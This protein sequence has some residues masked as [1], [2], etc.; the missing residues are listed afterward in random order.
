MAARRLP[1]RRRFARG[2]RWLRETDPV[3]LQ[4]LR[5]DVRRYLQ[6]LTLFGAR[7]GVMSRGATSALRCSVMRPASC[8]C[9]CSCCRW[10]SRAW[11]CGFPRTISPATWPPFP[12]EARPS[13]HPQAGRGAPGL[14][15]LARRPSRRDVVGLGRAIGAAHR[16][17][18][19]GS[20][21]GRDRMARS[22]G[23]GAAG[24]TRVRPGPASGARPRS[25]GRAARPPGG[26]VRPAL[27]GVASHVGVVVLRPGV[28]LGRL[29]AT[30][31]VR[32]IL[33]PVG[34]AA[35]GG[36]RGLVSP[37]VFKTVQPG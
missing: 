36:G 9:S 5:A 12:P 10:R 21:P 22:P 33:G 37:A 14:P 11:C 25:P 15:G 34:V 4:A 18:P 27:G 1:R 19:S 32:S 17:T 31:G 30:P 35:R 16:A 3:R 20:R 24:R 7:E 29:L 6:L 2:L 8:S 26:G 13:R 23:R 28:W